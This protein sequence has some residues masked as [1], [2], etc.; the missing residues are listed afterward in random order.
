MNQAELKIVEK[1][2]ALD[3]AA[4]RAIAKAAT[5]A[6]AAHAASLGIVREF[7]DDYKAFA[8]CRMFDGT[9]YRIEFFASY[10][11]GLADDMERAGA[12]TYGDFLFKT[13]QGE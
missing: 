1:T 3:V 7:A 13:S 10:F 5:R 12:E 11:A 4:F 2:N 8:P 6:M 9:R